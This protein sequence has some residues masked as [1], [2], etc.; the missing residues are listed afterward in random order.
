MTT[1]KPATLAAQ[2]AGAVER[3]TGGVVPGI[4]LAS[5]YG[6]GDGLRLAAA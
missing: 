4:S 2:A 6:R 1:W 5:T 3:D